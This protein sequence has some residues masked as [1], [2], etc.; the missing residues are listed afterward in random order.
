M[1]HEIYGLRHVRVETDA[2][3]CARSTA[4]PSASPGFTLKARIGE[5]LSPM[6]PAVSESRTRTLPSLPRPNMPACIY[7]IQSSLCSLKM[8]KHRS[9]CSTGQ[10]S[11]SLRSE[12]RAAHVRQE[13]C[14]AGIERID[15][16]PRIVTML[17]SASAV[18]AWLAKVNL[19]AAQSTKPRTVSWLQKYLLQVSR[20]TAL[21]HAGFRLCQLLNGLVAQYLN[22]QD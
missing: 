22:R 15:N 19:A 18:C 12:T 10:L 11:L 2:R 20:L 17:Q 21:S 3:K 6:T 13:R 14:F 4:Q 1:S 7:E 5:G 8:L 16:L 9:R